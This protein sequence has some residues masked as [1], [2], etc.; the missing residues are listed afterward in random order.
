[1]NLFGPAIRLLR[2]LRYP[3]KL[4]LVSLLFVVPLVGLVVL[5]AQETQAQIRITQA[6]RDGV[7]YLQPLR[8][9]L[10][11]MQQHRGMSSAYLAGDAS[12]GPR[13]ADKQREITQALAQARAVDA[14]Y[15]QLGLSARLERLVAAWTEV[16]AQA[17]QGSG[18]QSVARH[19]ACIA[20][21]LGL[22]S[23]AADASALTLDPELDTYYVMDAV[24]TRLPAMTESL[25]QARALGSAVAARQAASVE[26]RARLSGLHGAVRNALQGVNRG[27]G[28]AMQANPTLGEE[29]WR[30]VS[31]Q[32]ADVR[33][34]LEL[35]DAQLIRAPQV[36]L[37]A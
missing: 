4:G 13:L 17:T 29:M 32:E 7:E 1:M 22:M 19:T 5:L 33:A 3:Y 9:L 11:H 14:R 8:R 16:A 12:F 6:E 23:D 2:A 15:P 21:L 26:E 27:L 30:I 31:Q 10:E 18:A 20:Q 28:V 36:T 25:G 35:L 37:N 34:F 24:V